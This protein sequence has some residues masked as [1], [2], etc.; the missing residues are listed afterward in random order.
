MEQIR[1]A[2]AICRL[3][4]IQEHDLIN[5]GAA[6]QGNHRAFVTIAIHPSHRVG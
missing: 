1:A 3:R 2:T 5:R 4:C 6:S